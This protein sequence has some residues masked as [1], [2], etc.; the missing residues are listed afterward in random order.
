MEIQNDFPTNPE[1]QF[2]VRTLVN[3]SADI[4]FHP[5]IE[6]LLVKSGTI[7]VTVGDMSAALSAGD[8][9]AVG[10]FEPH[11]VGTP[12]QAV[13]KVVSIP[14]RKIPD[15]V[16]AFRN[17][18]FSRPFLIK[19]KTNIGRLIDRLENV[20]GSGNQLLIKGYAY[21][22]L[23]RAIE[24]LGLTEREFR[25]GGSSA[26]VREMLACMDEHFT[27]DISVEQ[28]AADLGYNKDYLSRVFN[29]AIGM[30]FCRYLNNMRV[31]YA[32]H[33]ISTTDISA[34]RIAEMSG[35]GSTHTFY[36]CFGDACGCT[37]GEYRKKLK[38]STNKKE[39][40]NKFQ[41]SADSDRQIQ[42]KS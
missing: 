17:K 8:I 25:R 1:E 4:H 19:G 28:I 9:A 16:S 23:G 26:V 41:V 35:F 21:L 13:V 34:E 2:T 10:R 15:F 33:L 12:R 30:G 37:P 6:L 7:E 5:E 42:K 29:E 24:F 11:M 27:E 32:I 3:P 14:V 40:V 39:N 20:S 38:K 18:T 31:K 22:I 36:D